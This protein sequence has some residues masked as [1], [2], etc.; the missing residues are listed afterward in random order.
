MRETMCKAKIVLETI[1]KTKGHGG[2]TPAQLQLAEAQSEDYQQMKKEIGELKT[3]MSEIKNGFN[4]FGEELA[5][6]KGRVDMIVDNMHKKG[7][8]ELLLEMISKK[9][10]WALL[11]VGSTIYLCGKFGIAIKDVVDVVKASFGIGG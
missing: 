3:D 4:S 7:F 9:G 2:M 6:V 11:I 8:V 5:Y 1:K 10:F